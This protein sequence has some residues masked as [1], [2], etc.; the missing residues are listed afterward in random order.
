MD[1]TGFPYYRR[2]LAR[3]HHLTSR[4]HADAC[5]PGIL[6]L[7]APVPR[8]RGISTQKVVLV[9]DPRRGARPRIGQI[10]SPNGQHS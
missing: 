7:L 5:A 10:E 6:A 2:G 4:A 8:V 1:A 9:D 3:V